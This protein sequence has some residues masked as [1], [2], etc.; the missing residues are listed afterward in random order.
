M[1]LAEAII[2]SARRKLGL[3]QWSDE[4]QAS[5]ETV[6]TVI[7]AALDKLRITTIANQAAD[8]TKDAAYYVEAAMRLFNALDPDESATTQ[9]KNDGTEALNRMLQAWIAEGIYLPN[10]TA[11]T[12]STDT[13]NVPKTMETAVI[14]NLSAYWASGF[15]AS[16]PQEMAQI[17]VNTQNRLPR[18]PALHM[19]TLNRMM[20]EWEATG[21][22]LGWSEVTA[23]SDTMPV[24]KGAIEPIIHNLAVRLAPEYD[25]EAPESVIAAAGQ[26][27]AQLK[28]DED[29]DIEALNYLCLDWQG[30]GINLGYSKVHSLGQNVPI[31]ETAE[32]AV[33]YNLA[34][35][36]APEYRME[37]PGTVVRIADRTEA[38][39]RRDSQE[40][41]MAENHGLP[42]SRR[43]YDIDTID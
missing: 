18:D 11:L 3:P 28:R 19:E 17:A 23:T 42:R 6:S 9:E 22:R 39:L 5:T 21:I 38:R 26:G 30:S 16:L 27:K 37:P 40:P 24:K 34:F 41:L 8:N 36:L 15:G 14:Y 1:P 2:D 32:Q 29:D 13:V 35:V 20:E 43:Y 33:V 4:R 12:A 25:K 10:F 31:P 7:D